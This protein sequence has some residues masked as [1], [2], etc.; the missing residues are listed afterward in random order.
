MQILMIRETVNVACFMYL[1]FCVLK[2]ECRN[3]DNKYYG[4]SIDDFAFFVILE[5]CNICLLDYF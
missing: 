3:I 4:I 1:S 2:K 5:V